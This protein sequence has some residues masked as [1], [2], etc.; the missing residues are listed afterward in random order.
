MATRQDSS[1]RA[2]NLPPRNI[3][4]LMDELGFGFDNIESELNLLTRFLTG[5]DAESIEEHCCGTIRIL[6]AYVEKLHRS[7]SDFQHALMSGPSAPA[8]EGAGNE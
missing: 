1:A 5:H 7:V 8:L 2:Q 3:E 6:T 4:R